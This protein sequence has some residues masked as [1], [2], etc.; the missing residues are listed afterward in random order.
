[1]DQK[2]AAQMAVAIETAF[3]QLGMAQAKGQPR[4]YSPTENAPGP[5]QDRP[6]SLSRTENPMPGVQEQERQQDDFL[7]IRSE[8]EKALAPEIR[9]KEVALRLQPDGLVVSLREV[10]FFDSGSSLIKP[11]AENAFARVTRVLEE[12]SC[13][14]RIE[15]HTDT[16]PIHNLNFASNWEL[17]TARATQV[18]RALIEKYDF[19]PQRLSAAG[20]AEFHP[21]ASNDVPE[22]RQLNR[23]VDVVIL[24]ADVRPMLASVSKA[25]SVPTHD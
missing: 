10:G 19:S 17:S 6:S 20:Y 8:L 25:P 16:I 21:I 7:K 14:I 9:R 1:M 11:A 18:V 12:H 13:A 3:Q 4:T 5:A 22:G 15:G 2:K 23:R 24:A